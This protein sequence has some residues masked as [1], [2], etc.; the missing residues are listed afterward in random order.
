VAFN[1]AKIGKRPHMP[2]WGR[3]RIHRHVDARVMCPKIG[4]LPGRWLVRGGV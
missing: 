2:L 3:L 1:A 4:T